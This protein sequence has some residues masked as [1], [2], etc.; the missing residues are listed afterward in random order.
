MMIL[1][2]FRF[3]LG[4][5]RNKVCFPKEMESLPRNGKLLGGK[6][7][8]ELRKLLNNPDP[9]C[10]FLRAS[11]WDQLC[12]FALIDKISIHFRKIVFPSLLWRGW[13]SA[14]KTYMLKF[15]DISLRFKQIP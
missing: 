13:S 14:M 4:H 15:M 3:D 5:E 2:H 7:V 1:A 9:T 12:E 11:Q 6:G 10:G 8:I